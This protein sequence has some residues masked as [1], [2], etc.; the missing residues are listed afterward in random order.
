MTHLASIKSYLVIIFPNSHAQ[1]KLC[2]DGVSLNIAKNY[3]FIV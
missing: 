2:E 1:Y 3:S